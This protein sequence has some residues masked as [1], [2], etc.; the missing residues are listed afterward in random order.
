MTGLVLFQVDNTDAEGRLILADALCYAETFNPKL[1]MD[2]A[3]LTGKTMA[4]LRS[5][6]ATVREK[7]MDNNFFQ[8]REKT[9]NLVDGQGNLERTGKVRE[10]SGK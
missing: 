5:R 8:V 6:V 10:K 3:T 9:G 7:Y 1:I 2:I 4:R